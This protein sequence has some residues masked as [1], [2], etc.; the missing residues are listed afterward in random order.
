MA[1]NHVLIDYENVQPKNLAALKDVSEGRAFKVYV[2]VGANQ[3]RIPKELAFEMQTLGA[4]AQ[5]VEIAGS[6]KNAADFHIAFYLGALGKPGS[7]DEFHIVSRD[8]GFDPLIRHLQAKNIKAA[9]RRDLFEIPW[10]KTNESESLGEK[11]DKVIR[12][13]DRRGH[14]RPRK[15]RTLKAS[16]RS[17]F[18]GNVPDEELDA[19]VQGLKERKY[20]AVDGERIRYRP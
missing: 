10:L 5:Y 14:S 1:T 17:L 7:D 4:D 15:V 11:I 2:F 20:V 18:G 13:F 19:L 6:G 9:R 16:I 8:T 3:S 12:N